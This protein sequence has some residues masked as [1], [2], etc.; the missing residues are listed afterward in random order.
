M[1]ENNL[2]DHS[3]VS[4]KE[5]ADEKW[6][7][8]DNNEFGNAFPDINDPLPNQIKEDSISFPCSIISLPTPSLMPPQ[9]SLGSNRSNEENTASVGAP[10]FEHIDAQSEENARPNIE[11]AQSPS[12]FVEKEAGKSLTN[13]LTLSLIISTH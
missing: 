11:S 10:D 1:D 7:E 2:F 3:Q 6:Q 5:F 13:P 8:W 4:F 12:G 9:T